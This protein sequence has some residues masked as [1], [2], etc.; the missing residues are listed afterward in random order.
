[1][2]DKMVFEELFEYDD[3][4]PKKKPQSNSF[5]PAAEIALSGINKNS[6][7]S[8]K[9][10]RNMRVSNRVPRIQNTNPR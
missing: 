1:M 10:N 4:S 5:T 6:V 7:Y 3:F 9:N 8:N 2:P